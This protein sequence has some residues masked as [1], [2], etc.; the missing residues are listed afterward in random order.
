MG[1]GQSKTRTVSFDNESS[2]IIDISEDVVSRLKRDMQKERELQKKEAREIQKQQPI[3]AAPV[4]QQAPTIIYHGAPTTT[5]MQVRKEKEAELFANDQYW[6]NR[7][8]NQESEFLKN[9]KIMEQ[10]FN[11]TLSEVKKR[12]AT[13]SIASQ[14]PPCQ[15][16][17]SKIIECYRKNPTETLKCS[18]EVREFLDCVN[19]A[20]IKAVDAKQKPAPSA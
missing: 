13:P 20:R 2:G 1:K 16:L 18:S 3:I 5:A 15:D 14:L 12:F 19:S 4:H 8:K 11:D 7:L 9:S 6:A 17:K 10:E